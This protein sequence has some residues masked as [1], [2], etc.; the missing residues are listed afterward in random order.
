MFVLLYG[1][2]FVF[3]VDQDVAEVDNRSGEVRI[4]FTT[5]QAAL[6]VPTNPV[7]VSRLLAMNGTR[8]Y[9]IATRGKV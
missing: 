8:E 7:Y 3:I 4:K 9:G 5:S 1:F 6:L 2:L